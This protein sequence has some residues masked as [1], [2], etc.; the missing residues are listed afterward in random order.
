MHVAQRGKHGPRSIGAI[1][2]SRSVAGQLKAATD[3]PLGDAQVEG[4]T[5]LGLGRDPLPAH[6]DARREQA[7]A[8]PGPARA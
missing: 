2:D 8:R 3:H 1:M 4:G 6:D 5:G 7:E